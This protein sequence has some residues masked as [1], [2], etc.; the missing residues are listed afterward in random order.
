MFAATLTKKP[1]LFAKEY[2]RIANDL[3]DFMRRASVLLEELTAP[4]DS[5][6]SVT[7]PKNPI[8]IPSIIVGEDLTEP[9]E[10]LHEAPP[11]FIAASG[12]VKSKEKLNAAL[13]AYSKSRPLEEP[14]DGVII[15]GIDIAVRDAMFQ[16]QYEAGLAL[17][18]ADQVDEWHCISKTKYNGVGW[19][20]IA[21]HELEQQKS[22][23]KINAYKQSDVNSLARNIENKVKAHRKNLGIEY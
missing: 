10:E 9:I 20:D 19:A 17:K 8:V 14:P 7:K 3:S 22:E 5:N 13:V 23:G 16:T 6:K 11:I 2:H 1:V 21:R 4:D 12:T 18:Y 15:E